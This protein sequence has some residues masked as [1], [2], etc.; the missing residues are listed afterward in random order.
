MNS[1]DLLYWVDYK[2]Y[3]IYLSTHQIATCSG[4][5]IKYFS[6]KPDALK[7]RQLLSEFIWKTQVSSAAVYLD[8]FR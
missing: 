7:K 5:S 8:I 1:S 3:K 6:V 2:I 4:T